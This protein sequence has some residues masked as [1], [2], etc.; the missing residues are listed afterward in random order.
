MFR[1]KALEPSLGASVHGS[2][3]GKSEPRWRKWVEGARKEG[4]NVL[5]RGRK[6]VRAR[7]QEPSGPITGQQEAWGHP[8]LP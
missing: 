2:Q 5:G 7:R 8:E 1:E 6:G 4:K 3:K